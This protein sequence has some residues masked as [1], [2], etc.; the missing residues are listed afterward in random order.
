MKLNLNL[1]KAA[2]YFYGDEELS[3]KFSFAYLIQL[4]AILFVNRGTDIVAFA[5][6]ILGIIASCIFMGYNL[7][8][9]HIRIVKPKSKLPDW[10]NWFELFSIGFKV[11]F[12]LFLV[13]LILFFI[14]Y[15]LILSVY[16]TSPEQAGLSFDGIKEQIT[17]I[18]L[19]EAIIVAY[20][21]FGAITAFLTDLKLKSFFNFK[22]IKYFIHD[23]FVQYSKC[24]AVLVILCAIL[25]SISN[26]LAISKIT[27]VFV[28]IYSIY[29]CLIMDDIQAQFLR[30]AIKIEDGDEEDQ[31]TLSPKK[32]KVK[33]IA[34]IRK[35]I[36]K[37]IKDFK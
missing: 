36:K 7:N 14:P 32:E 29:A 2:T 5:V 35:H 37:Y 33:I 8:N 10:E 26:T 23:N 24:Y 12:V 30:Y 28:P 25:W 3:K 1:I 4:A 16:M 21:I 9:A 20:F 31:K 19:I 27:L 22:I 17:N 11:H 6:V 13:V 15:A 18:M 34:K